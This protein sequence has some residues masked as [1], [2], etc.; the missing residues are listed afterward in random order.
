MTWVIGASTV[1]GYGVIISDVCVS[2]KKP[3]ETYY[4][5][6]CLQKIYPVGPS[7]LAGFSGSVKIGFALTQNLRDFLQLPED[8]KDSG[9]K[10]DWVA[11]NWKNDARR[12]FASFPEELRELKASILLVG[13]H[14]NE[15]VGIPG[16][17][18]IYGIV[19]KSPDFEPVIIS[20]SIPVFS[21][22]SGSEVDKYK[23]VIEEITKGEAWPHL[24]KMESSFR[25]G[26]ATGITI[27]ISDTIR[28][29]PEIGISKHLH[30]GVVGRHGY[31][32]KPNDSTKYELNPQI[33]MELD[34]NL[35][36]FDFQKDFDDIRQ[37][38]TAG[39]KKVEFKMPK[40]AKSYEEFQEL[41]RGIN[42]RAE[43]A[44]C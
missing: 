39:I 24:M 8:A 40:V 22:G 19:M 11:N 35:P 28:N 31:S 14:P 1:F 38:K 33:S 41:T 23:A 3:D 32:I 4:T 25:G 36:V 7:I 42:C 17:A 2:W 16:F 27:M 10:P 12:I 18:R 15:D 43:T 37:N 20:K 26:W 21:I 29:N 34:G 5:R 30:I 6:D 13:T 9:W 44:I